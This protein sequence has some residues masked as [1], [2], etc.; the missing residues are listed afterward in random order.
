MKKVFWIIL[1]VLLL[2]F[3][4]YKSAFKVQ[5]NKVINE[6]GSYQ[7]KSQDVVY[8]EKVKGFLAKP[9][10]VGAYPG[11]VMIHEKWGLND[12]IRDLA[13]S[14]ASY[15][16][17]VLA[18]DLYDG[19]EAKT[20]EEVQKKIGSLDQE[21]TILNMKAAVNYLKENEKSKKI[22]SLGWGFGGEQSLKLSLSGEKLNATVMYYG[23]LLLEEKK[24]KPITWPI[25]GVFG[26]KDVLVPVASAQIFD[27]VLTKLGTP[28]EV[29]IYPGIGNA[30]VNTSNENYAPKEAK[31]SWMKTVQFLEKYLKK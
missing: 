1:I 28:H 18:V 13:K 30:F 5:S 11:V 21:K 2:G 29:I 20:P 6:K 27:S 8:F 19:V 12:N 25:L 9:I 31:E 15:G 10:T 22:A 23:N 24:L 4:W 26:D 14:L 16:Y 3:I 7:V 17:S